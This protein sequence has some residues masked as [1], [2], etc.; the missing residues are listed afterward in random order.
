MHTNVLEVV[1]SCI[2]IGILT[3]L[4]DPFML[5]MPEMAVM[6]ALVVLAGLTCVWVGLIARENRGDEREAQHRAFAG[7]TAYLVGVSLLSL[8][9]VV[10][11]FN[12]AIDT[13]IVVTLGT[14]ILIKVAARIYSDTYL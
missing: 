13:W 11:G 8:A 3:V 2:L 4:I 1:L 7:R 14:M 9:L 10:Q 6:L 12:H 5:W